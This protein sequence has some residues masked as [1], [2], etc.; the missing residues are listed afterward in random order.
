MHRKIAALLLALLVSPAFGKSL[1]WRALD[2]TARLDADGRLHVTERHA[3]VFDGDWNGGERRFDIRPGQELAFHGVRKLVNVTE[4]PLRQGNL[5]IVDQ[6]NFAGNNTVRWR[7]RLPSDPPF[8]NQELIYLLDYDLSNIIV[9]SGGHYRL[10]HDFAFPDRAG[11]IK[12]FSLSLDV[13]PSWR[14]ITSP[15]EITRQNLAPGGAVVV[16]ADLTYAG[17]GS[18][19]AVHRIRWLRF[20]LVPA[21][22]LIAGVLLT[23]HFFVTEKSKGRF[24]ALFPTSL[25]NDTWLQRYVLSLPPEAVGAAWD[26]NTGAPEVGAVL[27]RMAQEKKITTWTTSSSKLVGSDN[28]LHLRLNADWSTLPPAEKELVQALFLGKL[29]T[30]TE[31]I[32]AHYASTGFR[33]ATLIQ[34]SIDEAL[35]KVPEWTTPAPLLSEKDALLIVIALLSF[36]IAF[37]SGGAMVPALFITVAV[38]SIIGFGIAAAA[39]ADV[40]RRQRAV[41]A[42]V[43]FAWVLIVAEAIIGVLALRMALSFA[44]ALGAGGAALALAA[45]ILR[46]SRSRDDVSKIEFRRRLAAAR[47]YF[48]QQLRAKDP[49]LRDD[50]FPYLIAFG[51]GDDVDQWFRSFGAR[52]SAIAFSGGTSAPSSGGGNSASTWTGGGGAFGGAGATGSWAAMSTIAAG[53]AAPSSSSGGGGGGGGS[54]GG[55]GGGW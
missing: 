40:A 49:K 39:R 6:W 42:P 27:A 30:D 15:L 33:P 1:Y 47:N 22:L 54:G 5:A 37:S 43:I 17:P 44:F 55:G 11:V 38:P 20:L 3:M 46:L 16:N 4:I 34:S 2:V 9:K 21:A 13:D 10:N 24:G 35:L 31:A 19:A 12:N 28:V 41:I 8:S 29:E 51:L 48:Q 18:P 50:W 23:V 32:R 52:S 7:S 26:E 45:L 25:I 53:V 14:G 36:L